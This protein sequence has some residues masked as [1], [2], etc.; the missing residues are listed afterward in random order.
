LLEESAR[1]LENADAEVE[2]GRALVEL[3]AALRRSGKR[4]AALE[5]L[6]RGMDLAHR[7][8]ATV[9]AARARVELVAAGARPRRLA[10]SGADALTASE[11]RVAAMASE[12]MTNREIA[13]ALFVTQRTVE[14][15]L[16]NAFAR[17]GIASR[18]DLRG[19]LVADGN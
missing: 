3:G 1:V 18:D 10:I 8:G 13:Q 6:A 17:L 7:R 9:L 11:R 5:S 15:H 12:G 19:A 4:A 14:G 16:S 2:H